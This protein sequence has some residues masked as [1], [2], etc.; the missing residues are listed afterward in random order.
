MIRPKSAEVHPVY[1]CDNCGSRHCETVEYVRK[2]GKILC[3]CGTV[4][5]LMPIETFKVSPVFVHAPK[6]IEQEKKEEIQSSFN[7]EKPPPEQP[8]KT[9]PSPSQSKGPII[10][11]AYYDK[12]VDLLMSL[13]Y[14]KS[15]S[16][17]KI[18][19]SV[20]G[21]VREKMETPIDDSNFDNFAQQL[22][23]GPNWD[24]FEG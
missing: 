16:K 14:K 11:A 3:E 9:I 17:K 6:K 21:W 8:K 5:S 4:L 22:I 12:A 7:V 23:L 18:N 20:N 19:D 1:I 15:E 2:I 10:E 13:G 24:G